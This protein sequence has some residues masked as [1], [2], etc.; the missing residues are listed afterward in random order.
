MGHLWGELN[1]H[2]SSVVRGHAQTSV[3]HNCPVLFN[4]W[5]K[6]MEEVNHSEG[7]GKCTLKPGQTGTSTKTPAL[8]PSHVCM[9]CLS[10][11]SSW[12]GEGPRDLGCLI[13][14]MLL[15]FA[16]FY[17]L[18]LQPQLRA[19][20]GVP[21]TVQG[22]AGDARAGAVHPKA[23]EQTWDPRD[24][25]AGSFGDSFGHDTAEGV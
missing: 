22:L 11:V 25:G 10:F 19:Q 5:C 21:G 17:C 13:T 12:S 3:V 7:G 16:A 4:H 15:L 2:P 8:T 24:A 23:A 1:I 18:H 20:H 9:G 14:H 6:R